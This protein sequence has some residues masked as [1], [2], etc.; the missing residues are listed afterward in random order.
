MHFVVDFSGEKLSC[1]FFTTFFLIL[2]IGWG[3]LVSLLRAR[4]FSSWKDWNEN[5]KFWRRFSYSW[6]SF[7]KRRFAFPVPRKSKTLVSCCLNYC[8]NSA[9]ISKAQT[10]FILPRISEQ[11]RHFG[12]RGIEALGKRFLFKL[13]VFGDVLRIVL[14][15]REFQFLVDVNN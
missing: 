5:D 13:F 9:N 1:K 7:S 12:S 15:S 4:R 11:F 3:K 10:Q 8:E 6:K 2:R 14:F